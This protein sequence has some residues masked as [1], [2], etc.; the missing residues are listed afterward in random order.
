MSKTSGKKTAIIAFVLIIAV[1]LLA[2]PI[3][4]VNFIPCFGQKVDNLDDPG[5]HLLE[6]MSSLERRPSFDFS[7]T[8]K[9]YVVNLKFWEQLDLEQV[10]V[11][12]EIDKIKGRQLN[13]FL[14]SIEFDQGSNSR[15]CYS[16]N[17]GN[18]NWY[19]DL[20]LAYDEI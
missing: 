20:Y 12:K 10:E 6:A 2:P 7:N 4:F 17:R 3:M 15:F 13:P 14:Y 5:E 9:L 11:L 18:T 1:I 19:Y 8:K 16:V